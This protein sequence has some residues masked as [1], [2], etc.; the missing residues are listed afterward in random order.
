MRAERPDAVC[1]FY[2]RLLGWTI[3]ARSEGWIGHVGEFPVGMI[4][5]GSGWDAGRWF[6]FFATGAIEAER[7]ALGRGGGR[8]LTPALHTPGIG[9]TALA[10]DRQGA[11]FGLIEPDGSRA[12]AAPQR[13]GA[14]CWSE[15]DTAA[16]ADARGFYCDLFG[17]AAEELQ[18]PTGAAYTRLLLDGVPVAGILAAEHDW[19]GTLPPRWLAYFT[20]ADVRAAVRDLAG[21]GG[22]L[23]IGPLDSAHGRVA[24]ARDPGGAAFC[25]VEP[26][27]AARP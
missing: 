22:S 9:R 23:V 4:I 20:V 15:L 6:C 13:H 17:Y 26:A 14:H 5:A 27:A 8:L 16:P 19:P 7:Y 1:E 25:I 10:Q 24:I 2:E 12:L 21:L 18:A 11:S 3:E